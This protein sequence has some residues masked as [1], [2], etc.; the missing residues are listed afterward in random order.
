M[1]MERWLRLIAGAL[2]LISIVLSQLHSPM[3]LI[4]AGIF[5]FSLFQSGF[6]NWCPLMVIL[7]FFGV[8]DGK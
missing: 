7:R 8:K 5:S 1:T 2:I 6:T 3:W 4:A